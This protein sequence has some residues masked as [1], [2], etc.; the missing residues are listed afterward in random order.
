MKNMSETSGKDAHPDDPRRKLIPVYV[1]L[2][3]PRI[4]ALMATFSRVVV[5]EAIQEALESFR[6]ELEG[7]DCPP[8]ADEIV[9]RIQDNVRRVEGQRLRPVVNATGIIL[10]TGLGRAVFPQKAVDA[11]SM[12]NRCSNMQ[13]DLETGLRGK[14]NEGTES[15]LRKLTGAEAAMVVNNNAAA[16]CL[17][18]MAL[19]QG[20]EVIVSRGQL[21]EIGG[22]YRLPSCIRQSGAVLVEVGTTNRTHLWDYE[23]ALSPGTGA[24]LRVNPSNY[25]IVG[26]HKEVPVAELATLKEKQPFL[27]IDDLGCGAL[28]NT[29]DYRLPKELTVQESIAA[30]ADVVCFSGDKLIGGAQA[31]IIVG[32]K[33]LIAKIKKHPFTRMLRVCKLTDLV[34][35]ETLRLFLEPETLLEN[36]PTLRMLAASPETLETMAGALEARLAPEKLP[37]TVRVKEGESAVGGGSMPAVPLETYVLALRSDSLPAERLSY[38]LRQNEPPIIARIHEDEV[39]LDMRTLME[40]DDEIIYQALKRMGEPSAPEPRGERGAESP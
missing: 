8:T 33:N 26:F 38:L 3:E 19:C 23:E 20:K 22:S 13:I 34:L 7:E 28:I 30:G 18:L 21:I 35:Q 32:K 1:L 37:F 16:T 14:R 39:L 10:H 27:L 9:A 36:H 24:I 4:Q 2:E 15:L 12:L 40:G 5:L 6:R 31:G 17:I 25:R 29:E 11:L